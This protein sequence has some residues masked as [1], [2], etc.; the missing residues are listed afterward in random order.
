MRS[1]KQ[2]EIAFRKGAVLTKEESRQ[3]GK[4]L[5]SKLSGQIAAL[6]TLGQNTTALQ[7]IHDEQA[8]KLG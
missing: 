4:D 3:L 7:Q 1:T 6:K 2:L 8:A 5:L